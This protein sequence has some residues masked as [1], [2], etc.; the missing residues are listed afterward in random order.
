MTPPAPMPF[1]LTIPLCQAPTGSIAG[2]ELAAAVSQ[3]GAL[4]AIA[5]TWTPPDV[6]AQA[7]RQIRALTANPFL[8][9]YALA[10]PPVSLTAALEAGA[11]LIAFSWG[12]PTPYLAQVRAAGAKIAIQVTNAAGARRAVALGADL[13]ICQGVEAGGHVQATR[14]L[15]EILPDVLA[16]ASGT[17]VVASGG[18]ADGVG[19]AR[20]LRLGASAA[21]LGTRFVATQESRAHP[22]YKRRLV[23]ATGGETAL[24]V[25]F[26]DG[27]P[28]AAHRVLRND[29]LEQWEAAGSPPGG[30]RPSEGEIVGFTPTGEPV[31]RYEDTAPRAGFTGDVE[32]MCLYAGTGCAATFLR[33]R[34]LASVTR[35]P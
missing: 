6:A 12:D 21:M 3:A 35:G 7:V 19:I 8:A 31:A 16:A 27:W 10:F 9:N 13:L 20:A 26:A 18:I 33:G 4:G 5:L 11:P 22:I 34:R 30:Q 15:W 14:S 2:P 25:C 1:P 29:T 17:P 23:E 32:A 28:Q 24:T